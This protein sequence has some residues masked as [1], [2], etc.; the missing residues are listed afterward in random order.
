MRLKGVRR[1]KRGDRV[2]KYHRATGVRLPDLP[3]LHPDFIAAWALAQSQI[4]SIQAKAIRGVNLGSI[5]AVVN[6]F[7]AS[8]DYLSGSPVYRAILKRNAEQIKEAY[9]DVPFRLI[10]ARHI[11]ADLSKLPPNPANARL[12]TWRKLSKFAKRTGNG[13]KDAAALVSKR[14][15]T[16]VGHKTWTTDDIASYRNKWAVGT[17]QRA[18]FELLYWTAART[19]DAVKLSTTNVGMDGILTF[20][21][22]KTKGPAYVPWT[23][24][25]PDF[26]SSWQC[27]RETVHHA[28]E[29]LKGGLTFLATSNGK[30]RSHKGLSN[31]IAAAAN[32]A[33]LNDC[34][35]HGLRK[36]RLTAIAEA[37]GT[38]HAIMAW[39][40]H[41]TLQ[42]VEQ[43]TRAAEMKRL[44]SGPGTNRNTVSRAEHDTEK[45]KTPLFSMRGK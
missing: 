39:G 14:K 3:E 34:T 42:E 37:G 24:P 2:V 5:A 18:C 36:A 28:V 27:E 31:V 16:I 6:N 19:I 13:D 33:G 25:L 35:A 1:Q 7:L 15:E 8:Q 38:A 32:S 11:E 10:E 30:M 22:S 9:A 41:K 21:Q 29:R 4:G 12:K 20:I 43:Y 44:I 23:A 40:G 45:A 26:A 17:V